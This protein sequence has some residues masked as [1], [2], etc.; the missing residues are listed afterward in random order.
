MRRLK[1]AIPGRVPSKGM[2]Q[3][4]AHSDLSS[5][6]AT[7][8][9]QAQGWEAP[10]GQTASGMELEGTPAPGPGLPPHCRQH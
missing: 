6:T 1:A 2:C 8:G 4:E 7:R 9:L 5:S 3:A 10:L